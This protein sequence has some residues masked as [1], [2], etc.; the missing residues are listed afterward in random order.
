MAS[1]SSTRHSRGFGLP[2]DGSTETE[3]ISSA[4]KPSPASA[5]IAVPLLSKPAAKPIGVGKSSP[6]MRVA[7][8]ASST[9]V[10]ARIGPAA[11]PREAAAA[12]AT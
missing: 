11:Q 2:W 4:P 12:S 10:T 8:L 7:S 5:R 6:A 9:A 3:P 1:S